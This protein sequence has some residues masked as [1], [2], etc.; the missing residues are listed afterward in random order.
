MPAPPHPRRQPDLV[1]V[2]ARLQPRDH[3]LLGLLAE[4]R[5]L[6][7]G[8]IAAALYGSL[9]MAQHRLR[10]LHQLELVDRFTRPRNRR[11]GGSA[12]WHWTLGR[13]GH[14]L[15][16]AEAGGGF[17]TARAARQQLARFAASPTLDHLVGVNSF[18]TWLLAHARTHPGTE[19]VRWWSE[20]ETARRYLG[21]HPDGHGLWRS[22]EVVMGFFLEYDTGTED[23][24]R[25]IP[26]LAAYERLARNGGPVYPV[27]FW[28][29]STVRET[30]LHHRL[31][32]VTSRC[33]IATAVR[34]APSL[35]PADP[36]WTVIGG[37]PTIRVALHD[38]DP[39][40]EAVL[41]DLMLA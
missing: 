32:G 8:Q 27:L 3:Q 20:Y 7:T 17:T 18:F 14:D 19:L 38:L 26:R 34:A 5:V 29:H 2:L 12:P 1:D 35:N 6:T 25:L 28:L 21:I 31:A 30:N 39:G 23:L 16:S 13:L 33:P 9:R 40:P 36:M 41:S 11:H 37:D 4:H 15:H 24:P 10:Q 22:G